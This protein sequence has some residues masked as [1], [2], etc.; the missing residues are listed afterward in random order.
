MAKHENKNC[1]WLTALL[2]FIIGLHLGWLCFARFGSGE[3]TK[4][5]VLS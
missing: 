2:F 5:I 4:N 3:A 1:A